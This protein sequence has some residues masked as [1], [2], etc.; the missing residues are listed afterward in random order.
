MRFKVTRFSISALSVLFVLALGSALV[1]TPFGSTLWRTPQSAVQTDTAETTLATPTSIPS[2]APDFGKLPLSFEPNVGQFDSEVKF[3]ARAKVNVFLT[4]DEAVFAPRDLPNT[5]FRLQFVGA[6]PVQPVG[7][8]ELSGKANYFVGNDP[9]KWRTKVSTFGKVAYPGLYPGVDLVFRGNPNQ[10]EYDFVVAPGADAQTIRLRFPAASLRIDGAGDLV[11]AS[12]GTELTLR[13]PRLY[14][15]WLGEER[16]ISGG[17]ALEDDNQV[18]FSVGEYDPTRPLVIDPVLVYATYLGGSD[19]DYAFAITV[20]KFGYAYVGGT[21]ASPNFPL[22]N[23]PQQAIGGALDAYVA[24]IDVDGSSLIYST[25]LGGVANDEVLAM[26]VDQFGSLYFVGDTASAN[27]PTT[28]GAFQTTFGGGI[29]DAFVA[30]LSPDGATLLYSTYLGGSSSDLGKGIVVDEQGRARVIGHTQ[31]SDFPLLNPLQATLGGQSDIFLASVNPAGS[32]LVYSTFFGGSGN[33]FAGGIALDRAGNTYLVGDTNSPNF[34][35]TRPLQPQIGG[36]RDAFLAKIAGDGSA[37]VYA[38][39]LGGSGD[40]FG[41][42]V[43]VDDAGSAYVVGNTASAN[44]PLAAPLQPALSGFTDAFVSKIS[45]DGSALVYS[46]YLGGSKSDSCSSITVDGAGT[47]HLTGFTSSIDFPT[48]SPSQATSGGGFDGFVTTIAPGGAA[49]QF[50]TYL[51]GKGTDVSRAIALDNSQNLY[52]AGGTNSTDLPLVR[53]LQPTYGGG[54]LDAFVVKLGSTE[55]GVINVSPTTGPASGGTTVVVQGRNFRFG[56]DTIWGGV[57]SK[58]TVL[59]SAVKILAVTPP[60]AA[61]TVDL[62]VT[63]PNGQS[64]VLPGAFTYED[65]RVAAAHS[66]GCASVGTPAPAWQTLGWVL[67]LTAI[68]RLGWRR[69]RPGTRKQP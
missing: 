60:H 17:Y 13:R 24:R 33:D 2:P 42:A 56:A 41:N 54:G 23:A 44:F 39:Y 9:S 31:S 26:Q 22:V 21:T 38:T 51:G 45:V 15:E 43:G 52:V 7:T 27:F 62:V 4:S 37:V 68:T 10:L 67:M 49:L 64:V 20:D 48:V 12:A 19:L 61:G 46:T 55:P 57:K 8:D 25:Y 29:N 16:E 6:N 5:A 63:N 40:E 66:R 30:R 28:P 1:W 59:D 69:A 35:T 47:A 14:Q 11:L 18:T 65:D 3:L 32:A 34:P 53:P 36:G 50:S 58:F